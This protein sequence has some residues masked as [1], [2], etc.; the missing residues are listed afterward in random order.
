MAPHT[1]VDTE[2]GEVITTDSKEKSARK[3]SKAPPT[4]ESMSDRYIRY[5]RFLNALSP[6]KREFVQYILKMRSRRGG[7]VEPLTDALDRWIACKHPE[8]LQNN[9]ARKRQSLKD[10]LYKLQI[11]SDEQ[12]LTR[13]HQLAGWS[14]KADKL[15]EASTAATI[16]RPRGVPQWEQGASGPKWM[17]EQK[18]IPPISDTNGLMS[19]LLRQAP[20]SEAANDAGAMAA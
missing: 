13:E 10:L 4:P 1:W 15:A 11:L 14:T 5:S 7:L 17:T 18:C 6:D 3:V 8:I 20:L 16:L 2:T 12:A 9:K 19:G